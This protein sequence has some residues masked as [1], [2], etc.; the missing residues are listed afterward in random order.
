MYRQ[1]WL[2]HQLQREQ[3]QL[4]RKEEKEEKKGGVLNLANLADVTVKLTDRK[5]GIL[6]VWVC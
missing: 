1:L 4:R 3:Q 2:Q 5:D 6:H